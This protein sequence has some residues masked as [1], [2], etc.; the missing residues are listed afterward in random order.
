VG[1]LWAEY[2][3]GLPCPPPG[4]LPNPKTK[5]RSLAFWWIIYHLSHQGSPRL[6]EKVAYDFSRG[7]SQ[8]RN[9]IRVSCIAGRFFTS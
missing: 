8:S 7:S 2:W 4:D 9:E 3:S 1:I 5:P 6:L